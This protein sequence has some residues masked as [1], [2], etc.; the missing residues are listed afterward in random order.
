MGSGRFWLIACAGLLFEVAA[1]VS[2]QSDL[3][4]NLVLL[5]ACRRA[6]GACVP[7]DDCSV[8]TFRLRE[9]GCP[10]EL[11]CCPK[12]TVTVTNFHMVYHTEN[13]TTT[14]TE[15]ESEEIVDLST[16]VYLKEE[17][18]EMPQQTIPKILYTTTPE[19]E[20][21]KTQILTTAQPTSATTYPSMSHGPQGSEYNAPWLATIFDGNGK[22]CCHGALISNRT[23]LTAST[24]WTKCKNQPSSWT[25]RFALWH[26]NS[27]SDYHRSIKM[28]VQNG[29]KHNDFGTK[30][31]DNNIAV[32]FLNESIRTSQHIYPISPIWE[33]ESIEN[34]DGNLIYTGWSGSFAS[35]PYVGH[36]TLKTIELKR[37][38]ETY[39]RTTITEN[40]PG[41][42]LPKVNYLCVIVNCNSEESNNTCIVEDH[43]L[44]YAGNA[45][46]PVVAKLPD[47]RYAL[48]G[49][50][51][52]CYDKTKPKVP[53]LV[54]NVF[55]FKSWI[56]QWI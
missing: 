11:E 35:S 32:L 4:K 15:S 9:D 30:P 46:G 50:I 51:A 44:L 47:N 26:S 28:N 56:R 39:C 25:V 12:A 5:Q 18:T 24:C 49:L 33:K 42:S 14:N 7:K 21:T 52:R 8:P 53:T 23:V 17:I 41:S 40:Q 45:G 19:P 1:G 54:T 38:N 20:Y 36:Y 37:I 55:D 10:S 34:I 48:Y 6:T 29:T 22:Y 13:P 16:D 2:A 31:R 43:K 27:P 3:T